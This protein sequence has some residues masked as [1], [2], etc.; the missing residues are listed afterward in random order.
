MLS[1][2]PEKQDNLQE[3]LEVNREKIS[4]PIWYFKNQKYLYDWPHA[5][6][7]HIL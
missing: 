1:L 4:K 7:F 5:S 2:A 3:N 6:I